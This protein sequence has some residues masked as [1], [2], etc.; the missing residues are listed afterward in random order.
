[1]GRYNISFLDEAIS[2]GVDILKAT[3][4]VTISNWYLPGITEMTEYGK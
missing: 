2:R 3:P 1:M 4:V